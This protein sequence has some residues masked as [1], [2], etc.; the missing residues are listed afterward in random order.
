M[1]LT[2]NII[3]GFVVFMIFTGIRIVRPTHRM[4]IETLGKYKGTKEQGFSWIIPIIQRSR[5][6]NITEQM[7]DVMPQT[8]ITQDNLNATVDA[9]VYYQI[10]D[11][12][13]SEYNVDDHQTQLVSLARTT[14]RAVM[15]KMTLTQA[16]E[17]RDDINIKVEKILDKETESY[18]VE[19]LRVEIQKIEA[20]SDVQE[21]MNEVV[22]AE[23]KKIA[24]KDLANA[25][26]VEADGN[27][28]AAVKE[29]SGK[30]EAAILEAEGKAKA[31]AL[32]NESFKGNA[33]LDKQLE[34]TRDSLKDNTKVLLTENGISPNIILGEIPIKK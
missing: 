32:I 34:I 30:R 26:E 5:Y 27:R 12:K 1:S 31:F 16:N 2:T 33:Q 17:N 6:V 25:V 8:V 10:K 11:V 3:I 29:A 20:P 15:G 22:K 4:L 23:R 24:A 28:R 9:V 7:V 13:K 18:G 21:A 19:V 14:L